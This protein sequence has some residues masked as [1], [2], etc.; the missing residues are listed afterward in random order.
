MHARR[1][2]AAAAVLVFA[3]SVWIAGTTPRPV[4]AAGTG[5]LCGPG[6]QRVTVPDVQQHSSLADVDG[7]TG[8]LWAVG[9]H[10]RQ[11][12]GRQAFA[13]HWDGQSWSKTATVDHDGANATQL[14]AVSRAA[15]DDVWAVGSSAFAE[16]S[17]FFTE[18]WNGS[19]WSAVP[20][21]DVAGPGERLFAVDAVA[22]DD[23]WAVGTRGSNS[24]RTAVL[25]WDG[26]TWSVVPSPSPVAGTNL[27]WAVDAVSSTQAWAFGV[28]GAGDEN[29]N[30]VALVLRWNGTAWSVVPEADDLP[31]S[32][33]LRD[34]AVAP[35]G[36]VWTAGG[37][38]WHSSITPEAVLQHRQGGAWITRSSP[39]DAWQSIS[40]LS[41]SDVWL[42]SESA[43]TA[44]W[45]GSAATP[46]SAPPVRR[47]DGVRFATLTA[48]EALGPAEVWAVG[49]SDGHT[50][51]TTV[52]VAMRLCPL[53]VTDDGIA[54]ESSRVSQGSG[55][56][57]RFPATNQSAHDV[58][59][60]IGLG[61][62]ASPLFGTGRRSPG[63]TG[64]FTLDHAGAFPVVDTVT[65]HT[66]ELTVPTEALPRVAPLGTTFDVYTA[67]TTVSLG[68]SLGSDIRYRVPGSEFWH[69]LPSA[70]R[71]AITPFE[72][73]DTGVYTF[74]ARLR[75]RATGLVSG[76]SP[77]ATIKVTAP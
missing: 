11:N 13:V 57:W 9:E 61:P 68:T 75:N 59:D 70:T 19:A 5:E 8:D 43:S 36:D 64:T 54:K 56:L 20:S 50:G 25:H 47:A 32:T 63:S 48:V 15:D 52:P 37:A 60:A 41:D 1:R 35:D 39:G 53:R 76:W 72:P 62:S 30:A 67:A 34:G 69:R 31:A 22:A 77:F 24:A 45:D 27:L 46:L 42:L 58:T 6:W 49:S 29:G 16:G 3:A 44:H 28:T 23:V 10:H 4:V 33:Y 26:S 40:P 2:S 51:A 71:S 7:V 74:Q 38:P 12:R 17:R 21:P 14:D 55:T 73:E 65:G 18:H 66:S